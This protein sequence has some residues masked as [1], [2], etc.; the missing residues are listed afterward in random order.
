MAMIDKKEILNYACVNGNMA[1][2]DLLLLFGP[3]SFMGTIEEFNSLLYEL[4]N[5]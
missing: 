5:K 2:A 1:A 3:D 4:S